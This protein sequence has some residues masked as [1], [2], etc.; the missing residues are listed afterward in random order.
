MKHIVRKPLLPILLLAVMVFAGC[1]LAFFQD[2]IQRDR[3]QV[4][5]LY[6]NTILTI[7]LLPGDYSSDLLQLPTHKRD[8]L[9]ALDQVSKTLCV[10]ECDA[11]LDNTDTRIYGTND[12][13]WFAQHRDLEVEL[14]DGWDWTSFSERNN[15]IPCIVGINLLNNLELSL[16]QTVTIIPVDY[17]G[18]QTDRNPEVVMVV[19]GFFSD[20]THVM[21]GGII[22]PEEIFLFGPR[23]L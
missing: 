13:A 18:I 11:Q 1:F 6:D 7:E 12:H 2:G 14:W 9:E 5:G 23:L 3:A 16:G 15:M 21:D 20:P 22:V 4:E 10:M 8:F 19:A 17:T